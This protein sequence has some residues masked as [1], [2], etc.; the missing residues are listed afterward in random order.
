MKLILDCDPG[1]DD[2]LAIAACIAAPEIELLAVTAVP[3]NRPVEITAANA[4]ALTTVFGGAAIPVHAGAALPLSAFAPRHNLVHGEDGLG[5]VDLSAHMPAEAPVLGEAPARILEILRR[6]P[7][8][9]VTL[10]PIGPLTNLAIAQ[11]TDP[12]TFA[13]C[14]EIAMM[15]GAINGRGNVTPAAEFNFWADPVAAYRV[16]ASGVPIR[17]FGL[18]VT[19]KVAA[20]PDWLDAV[21]ALP[22]KGGG[23]LAAMTRVYAARDPI[24]HDPCAVIGLIRPELFRAAPHYVT[25]ET[26]PGLSDGQSLG[27]PE[28][29]RR[30]PA[31]PNAT[32]VTDCDGAEVLAA[33]L[34][35]YRRL[36]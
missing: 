4:R 6:E 22:G 20:T 23:I 34:E 26:A 36:P 8:G 31:P 18:D 12:L 1:I 9:T 3:G 21:A 5:G 25:V 17:M 27:W 13:R 33:L 11:I 35:L 7:A 24:L 14:R 29:H 10:A 2:A 19:R 16:F 32:V 30:I 15:G 28:G